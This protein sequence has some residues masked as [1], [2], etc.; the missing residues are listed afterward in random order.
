MMHYESISNLDT[1][2]LMQER[3][4]PRK[5]LHKVL[6]CTI[7]EVS[8]A[9]T[10]KR[11]CLGED[12]LRAGMSGNCHE[13]DVKMF[14]VCW[15]GDKAPQ[16]SYLR[17]QSVGPEN[18]GITRAHLQNN[19]SFLISV[20]KQSDSSRYGW[21]KCYLWLDRSDRRR[22]R[23]LYPALPQS[24]QLPLITQ[25]KKTTTRAPPQTS[26]R[27]PEDPRPQSRKLRLSP[28]RKNTM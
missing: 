15:L 10:K 20:I 18:S 27:A 25:K 4:R 14:V 19:P 13:N 8:A 23:S 16:W 3:K 24:L 11:V 21:T 28:L 12:C 7:E 5:V 2:S 6:E 1:E 26:P 22:K 9:P 17:G